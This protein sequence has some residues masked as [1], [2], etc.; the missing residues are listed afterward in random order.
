MAK[1]ERFR[2]TEDGKIFSYARISKHTLVVE[3]A[4]T[5]EPVPT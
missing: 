1:A 3:L 4:M 2:S 5:P